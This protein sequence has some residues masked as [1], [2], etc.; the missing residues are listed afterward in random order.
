MPETSALGKLEVQARK[1]Q[2]GQRDIL[3]LKQKTIRFL[4]IC[5]DLCMSQCMSFSD[6]I[7]KVK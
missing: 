4:S 3:N 7:V 2:G 6:N 5:L 1:K